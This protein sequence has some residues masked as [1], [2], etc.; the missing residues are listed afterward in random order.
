MNQPMTTDEVV[1]V[2]R[3]RLTYD[4]AAI[5]LDDLIVACYQRKP[6]FGVGAHLQNVWDRRQA[7]WQQ[8][9]RAGKSGA[10]WVVHHKAKDGTPARPGH[11][12][13]FLVRVR[14]TDLEYVMNAEQ[15]DEETA[16]NMLAEF[17]A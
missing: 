2:I 3:E 1:A 6:E 11:G 7:V 14:P 12:V 8:F 4:G 5:S 15:V 17:P 16:L 9:Y 13:H 10:T